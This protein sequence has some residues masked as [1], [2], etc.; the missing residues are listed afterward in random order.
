[1]PD[2]GPTFGKEVRAGPHLITIEAPDLLYLRLE[3]DVDIDHMKVFLEVVL[4]LPAEVHVLRDGRTSRHVGPRA[5]EFM[6]K[7]APKG[8]IVSYISFGA[9]LYSRTVIAMVARAIRLIRHDAPVVGFTTTE[10]EARVWIEQLR[11]A[12]RRG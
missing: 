10:A 12:R 3:G 9:S 11:E 8:K 5:R 6:L 2:L 4:A 7:A 1:M